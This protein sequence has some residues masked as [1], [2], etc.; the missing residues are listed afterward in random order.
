MIIKKQSQNS[1]S[2]LYS[3]NPVS[4]LLLSD[5]SRLRMGIKI[6][7][8]NFRDLTDTYESSSKSRFGK[9]GNGDPTDGL[10]SSVC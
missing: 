1:P 9:S 3:G 7:P 4:S 8:S 5:S 6:A 2:L 10:E